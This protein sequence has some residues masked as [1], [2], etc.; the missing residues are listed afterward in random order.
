M[1]AFYNQKPPRAKRVAALLLDGAFMTIIL[2]LAFSF[3][4]GIA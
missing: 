4:V 1:E 2:R 3:L